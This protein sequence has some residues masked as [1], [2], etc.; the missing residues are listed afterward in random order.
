[1]TLGEWRPKVNVKLIA[2][3]AKAQLESVRGRGVKVWWKHVKG[4]SGDKGN[5][6]ANAL[7]DLGVEEAACEPR[8]KPASRHSPP[9]TPH[10]WHST[11]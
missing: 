11:R 5:D 4:H 2:T 1:M 10:R 6:R 9:G 8:E 3:P 7:A